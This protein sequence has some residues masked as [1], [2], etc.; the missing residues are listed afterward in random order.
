MMGVLSDRAST[1][2]RGKA[3]F[4]SR[5]SRERPPP[6]LGD[7]HAANV[8][9]S[10]TGV[11]ALGLHGRESGVDQLNHQVHREAA[12]EHDRLGA[13]LAAPGEQF[14]GMAAVGLGRDE[15]GEVGA[16]SSGGGG[17]LGRQDTMRQETVRGRAGMPSVA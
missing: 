9:L 10:A 2:R 1:N 3:A 14:E 6:R 13:A 8:S 15:G 11:H 4:W 12:R 16:W 5:L 7:P 17:G